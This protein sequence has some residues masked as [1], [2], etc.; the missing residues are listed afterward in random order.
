MRFPGALQMLPH[1]EAALFDRCALGRRSPQLD[2]GDEDWAAPRADDLA[3][4]ARF[5]E[6]VRQGARRSRAAALRRRPCADAWWAMEED[7]TAP[8]GQ[9]IRFR[10][11]PGGRRP[12]ALEHRHPAG[13]PRLVHRR[14]RTATSPGTS[15]PSRQSST[16]SRRGTTRRLPTRPPAVGA[17]WRAGDRRCV[18]PYRCSPTPRTCCWP[19]WAAGDAQRACRA[20]A[21][22]IQDQGGARP[23]GLREPPGDGRPLCRRHDQRRRAAARRGARRPAGPA[24]GSWASIRGRSAPTRWCS[25][26]QRGRR[27]AIVV[28][29][30]RSGRAGA[31]HA[32][33]NPAARAAG[34]RDRG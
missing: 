14:G 4:A 11:E 22:A 16:C 10:I 13:H 6:H 23:S 7:P 25:I 28:G 29:P 18:T 1:A 15:R 24:Q 12:G 31:R 27:G 34:L 5:R 9:R 17:P 21:A 30:G 19:G 26:R 33:G 20:P 3:I 32:A 2:P 8:A